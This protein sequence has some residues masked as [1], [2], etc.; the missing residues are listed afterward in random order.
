LGAIIFVVVA[1]L[2]PALAIQF[3]L[4]APL[5]ILYSASVVWNFG[6]ALYVGYLQR[7]RRYRVVGAIL[8]LAS[9][10]AVAGV[11]LA[12]TL[13]RAHP[14]M[15]L[16]FWQALAPFGLFALSRRLA[17]A[18]PLLPPGRL[19]PEVVA[20]TLGVGT[21]QAL[22][23][24]T[25]VLFAKAHLSTVQAG[26][27]T[28]LSTIGQ[29]LP[30][31]VASLSTV[32]LTAILDEPEQRRAYLA[33]TLAATGLLVVLFV[34]VLVVFPVPVVRLAL[35]SAFI[36]MSH[37]VERYGAATAAMALVLVLTTYGVAMGHYRTMAA[38]AVGTG[39][40]IVALI[41][42]HTM[43]TLVDRTAAA[44]GGTLVLVVVVFGL[45]RELRQ[46]H[47]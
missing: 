47:E 26:L 32:M 43:V 7:A 18:V 28:G 25:D 42:A 34:G 5:I 46:T 22:W 36:P 20:T 40:W 35:G 45:G 30:F 15:W 10:S 6:Y 8:V 29:A 9:A 41:G 17:R 3:H 33:R 21:L 4:P 23:G 13:G 31:V 38:A 19:R 39:I 12:V 24:F 11:G 2:S 44:M 14:L 16:G 37:L 27:Y 1:L